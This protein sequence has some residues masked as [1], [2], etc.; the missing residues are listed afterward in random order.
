MFTNLGPVRNIRRWREVQAVLFRY[1][2][3]F[4]LDTKEIRSIQSLLNTR[5]NLPLSL[6]QSELAKFSLPQRVRLMLQELGPTFVKLGQILSSRSDLLPKE[7]IDELSRLQDDVPPFAFEEVQEIISAELGPIEELFLDFDPEPIAA[8]SIGQVHNAILPDFSEVVVKV[9]RPNIG[10]RVNSDLVFVREIARLINTRTDWGKKYG[11]MALVDEMSRTINEEMDYRFEATNADRLRW[12][13]ASMHRVQVPYMYWNLTTSRVLTMEM[14]K[15]VKVN[16]LNRIDSAGLDREELAKIFIRSIFKQL[17]VDGFFHADP[18]PANILVNLEEKKLAYI[19]LGMMGSLL[20]EQREQ[21]GDILLAILQRD[22]ESILRLALALGTPFEEVNEIK[23]RRQM[24]HLIHEYMEAPLERF[25]FSN[26]LSK[27][28]TTIFFN[29]IRL[30]AE[31]GW[32]AK[33]LLQGEEVGRTLYPEILIGEI[34]QDVSK[35]VILNK[36]N[37]KTII[38]DSASSIR[39]YASLIEML[40][41]SLVSIIRQI[42]RGDLRVR[43]EINDLRELVSQLLIIVNRLITGLVL[44]GMLIGSALAMSVSKD[45]TWGVIPILGT[46][47]FIL[48]MGLGLIMFINVWGDIGEKRKRIKKEREKRFERFK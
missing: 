38:M 44:V 48:S 41:N 32:A 4:L 31:L 17:L 30:P 21:L 34:L 27:V 12:N 20:P 43:L 23:L 1:G 39:E 45:Q 37:P 18:H 15:G 6:P 46:I 36:L 9:Q 28:L 8:A 40:P 13:L 19:D 24:A 26:L 29:G 16:D 2:F 47:G 35:Q 7:W 3:D 14:I 25:S 11:V 22:T 33:T 42:E 5:L 10:P